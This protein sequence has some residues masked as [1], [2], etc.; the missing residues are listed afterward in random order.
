MHKQQ[1]QVTINGKTISA[2]ASLSAI[3]AL[4][5]AGESKVEGVGCLE[6]VCGSCTVMVRK[7]GCDEVVTALGCQTFIEE[8]MNIVFLGFP[9]PTYH[10]YQ[11]ADF[12][13][14]WEVQHEFHQLFPE[15]SH[16]RSC[17]GCD[18]SCPKSISVEAGVK[19]ACKGEFKE[20]ADLFLECVMCNLCMTSCPENIAPN[21][22]GL[23]SRRINA[24]FH[25]R[26]ANLIN[27]L[28]TIQKGE[29]T[30]NK[31]R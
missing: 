6:G 15:A 13:N 23:F 2:P 10:Q 24:Y 30:V 21:H 29:L 3:Q 1:V 12:Q 31:D 27:R 19:L 20:A 17:G 5:H 22:V 28:E 4:W 7:P 16:C 8:G 14:S 9:D 18:K 25:M 11:L 26:P